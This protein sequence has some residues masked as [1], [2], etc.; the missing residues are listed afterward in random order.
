MPNLR[1]YG[2]TDYGVDE[3]HGYAPAT[4]SPA[5]NSPTRRSL[6]V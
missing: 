5:S 6:A 3:R 2:V 4:A 1:I